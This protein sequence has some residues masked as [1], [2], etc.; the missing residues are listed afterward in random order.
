MNKIVVSVLMVLGL[1]GTVLAAGNA[2]TGKSK[3]MMCAGCHGADGNSLAPNFPKLAGQG[4]K[5]L[6]KQMHDIKAGRRNVVEMTG[7]LTAVSDQDME[8]IAAYFASQKVTIGAAK[9]NLVKE[10]RRLYRAG[11][12]EDKVAACTACH[13]PTGAGVELAG[14]PQ[15]KG[16]HAVYIA[17]QLKNFRNGK[18]KNDG[19]SAMMRTV[20]AKLTDKEIEA[21]ASYIEGLHN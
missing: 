10:G 20:A 9:P 7:I 3:A 11:N 5:Y 8:D 13:G 4:E 12:K 1:V 16:Q 18:R 14:F 17:T 2:E 15:L 21:V 19:E 6:L